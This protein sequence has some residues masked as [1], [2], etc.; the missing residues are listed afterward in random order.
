MIEIY[1]DESLKDG[2]GCLH[3]CYRNESVRVMLGRINQRLAMR[4]IFHNFGLEVT[5]GEGDAEKWRELPDDPA[6]REDFCKCVLR[7]VMNQH[8]EE[9]IQ[10]VAEAAAEA[11]RDGILIGKNEVRCKFEALFD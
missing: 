2:G 6:K 4:F 8:L 7:R 9:V 10:G 1:L 5:C 11:R 3:G